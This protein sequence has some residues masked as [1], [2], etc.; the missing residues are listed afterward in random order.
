VFAGA[1]FCGGGLGNWIDRVARSGYV[2]D[3]LQCGI[4]PVRTGIF[5]LAD[6]AV[7]AGALLFVLGG[8]ARVPS[9]PRAPA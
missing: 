1:L 9:D 7:M 3:F 6:V 2:V 4:G 8:G 5:N